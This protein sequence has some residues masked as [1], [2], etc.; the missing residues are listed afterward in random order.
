MAFQV[1]RPIA[2]MLQIGNA[3]IVLC[4]RPLVRLGLTCLHRQCSRPW[5]R[6][7]RLR[8]DR[9]ARRHRHWQ[10]WFGRADMAVRRPAHRD[11]AW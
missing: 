6:L 4:V 3:E 2:G 5:H 8:F 1:V 10:G 11:A 9:R 7:S